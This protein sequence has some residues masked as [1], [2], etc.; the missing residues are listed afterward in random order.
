M[1]DGPVRNPLLD[2]IDEVEVVISRLVA[3]VPAREKAEARMLKER[4]GHLAADIVC[5]AVV[6]DVSA[7]QIGPSGRRGSGHL[8]GQLAGAVRATLA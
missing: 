8:L 4:W 7:E 1:S 6:E 3:L 5:L 2:K